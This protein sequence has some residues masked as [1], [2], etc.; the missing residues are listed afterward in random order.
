MDAPA[1]VD[2]RIGRP[3]RSAEIAAVGGTLTALAA[4]A[5]LF[6]FGLLIALGAVARTADRSV[7]SLIL[8]RT[9]RGTRRSDVPLAVAASPL[10]FILGALASIVFSVVPLIVAVG[11]MFTVAF[12]LSSGVGGVIEP[13]RPL[14][15]AAGA[16]S[17][18]LAA[19][20]GPGGASLRRGTR[21]LI[22][23]MTP[24]RTARQ[25]FLIVLGVI[26]LGSVLWL[27]TSADLQP[28]WWPASGPPQLP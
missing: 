8:R 12:I 17:G 22:R 28:T 2:P 6:A 14:P 27:T 15:L 18:V 16:V 21:S 26:A 23:G 3:A 10:H 25:V 1:G 20:W 24:N 19:W 11:V 13:I 5:P 7:T 4:A 9:E